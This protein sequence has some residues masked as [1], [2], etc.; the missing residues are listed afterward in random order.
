M[1]LSF[2]LRTLNSCS[3]NHFNQLEGAFC[4]KWKRS[5]PYSPWL[6]Q[7]MAEMS[8]LRTNPQVGTSLSV[9]HTITWQPWEPPSCLGGRGQYLRRCSAASKEGHFNILISRTVFTTC[10]CGAKEAHSPIHTEG[11]CWQNR[12]L[13]FLE[14]HKQVNRTTPGCSGWGWRE[15]FVFLCINQFILGLYRFWC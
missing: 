11:H 14:W 13:R 9:L 2:I 8:F 3:G 10:S 12:A 4:R 1:H 7:E 5:V 15:V 6:T